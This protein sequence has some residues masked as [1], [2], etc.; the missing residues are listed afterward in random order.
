[1]VTS[2]I[3]QIAPAA[4]VKMVFEM[5][6]RPATSTMDGIMVMSLVPR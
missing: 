4:W 5:E 1:M 2:I 3:P 6:L